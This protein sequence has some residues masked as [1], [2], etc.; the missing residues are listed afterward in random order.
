[1]SGGFCAKKYLSYFCVTLFFVFLPLEGGDP[2]RWRLM[3]LGLATR[4]RD[5]G[6]R[7]GGT[8]A[9]IFVLNLM[10][11]VSVQLAITMVV[12]RRLGINFQVVDGGIWDY[13]CLI[14]V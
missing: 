14:P 9:S 1:M 6:G 4:G 2:L 8:A 10:T 13:F 12:C 11:V 5:G 3:L 7:D